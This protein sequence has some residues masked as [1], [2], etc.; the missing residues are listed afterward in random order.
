MIGYLLDQAI[1]NHLPARDVA[2]LLTQVVVDPS[3]PAFDHPTKPIGPHYDE[4]TARHMATE[5]GWAVAPDADRWRRV[6]ASPAPCDIVE[7]TTIETLLEFNVIVVCTGGGG[8]PVSVDARGA[9]HGVEA[10]I[11]K[12]A[13]SSLLAEL[14]DA[15]LLLLLTDCDGAFTDWGTPTQTLIRTVGP[16][17]IDPADF[18]AG[19]MAPKVAAARQFTINTGRDAAI[20]RLEDAIAIVRGETGTRISLL[21]DTPDLEGSNRAPT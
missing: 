4:A 6:V 17:D 10:V 18:S 20:G 2:T 19:A 12:D 1:T 15:D 21:A 14:L 7:L 16:D 8:I 9:L 3:D 13:A 11:D 5:H